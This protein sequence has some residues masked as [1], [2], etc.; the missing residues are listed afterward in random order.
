MRIDV[1]LRNY[2]VFKPDLAKRMSFC[3]ILCVKERR[4]EIC[5]GIASSVKAIGM[6]IDTFE[7]IEKLLLSGSIIQK[8]YLIL[9]GIVRLAGLYEVIAQRTSKHGLRLLGGL[10]EDLNRHLLGTDGPASA[11]DFASQWT[12]RAEWCRT[13]EEYS[14]KRGF[15]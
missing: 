4:D 10:Y 5:R 2:N 13:N 14:P 9:F 15:R 8:N 1:S 11:H 7:V 6:D 3:E 12:A